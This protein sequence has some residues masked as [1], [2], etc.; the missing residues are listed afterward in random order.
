MVIKREALRD[1]VQGLFPGATLQRI[2]PL[3]KDAAAGELT[4]KGAGYGVPLRLTIEEAD[5]HRR[6]LV[7]HTAL[8]NAFGHDRRSDRAQEM[9]LAYDTFAR[10]PGQAPALDVGVVDAQGALRS[11]R[12]SGEFY[13]VTEFAPGEVY[14]ADLRR[15]AHRQ[16]V[17]PADERRCDQLVDYLVDLHRQPLPPG[18]DRRMAYARA[19]R[20]LVGHGEGIFGIV[21][22]YPDHVSG[23]PAERLQ[24][25]EERC[26]RWR[27]RLRGREDRLAVTHGD[28]HPFNILFDTGAGGH[29]RLVLLDASRGCLGDPADD[30]ACLAINYVFFALRDRAA[31]HG[32]LG[33]L[34]HRFWRRYI[35]RSGDED[36]LEAA[37]PFLTW[38]ALV[39]ANPVWY[40]AL[41]PAYRRKLLDLAEVALDTGRVD[42]TSAEMLFR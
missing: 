2:V 4:E 13:L 24:A 7:W 37:P 28:F 1:L 31:W 18:T 29:D 12:N 34:W 11:L 21:D 5:G 16:A 27:W 32:A 38:R 36:I 40:P 25:L 30:V 23:A 26:C 10:V 6:D 9:L 19:I 42:P 20:D 14:A 15:M 35:D 22:G 39:L 3:G 41:A 8:A 17:E 33:P